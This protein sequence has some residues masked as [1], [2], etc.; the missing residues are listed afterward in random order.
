MRQPIA[1][2]KSAPLL[3]PEKELISNI[4]LESGALDGGATFELLSPIA[5]QGGEKC[6]TCQLNKQYN[7]SWREH[8]RYEFHTIHLPSSREFGP[9][10]ENLNG[11]HFNVLTT[12][13]D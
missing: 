1:A 7:Q 3:L 8:N 10:V 5:G 11:E 2:N 13:C 4:A 6:S 12:K 9:A